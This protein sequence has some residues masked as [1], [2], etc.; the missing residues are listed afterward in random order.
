VRRKIERIRAG[1]AAA[2][3]A[4]L[5]GMRLV[6]RNFVTRRNRGVEI[7]LWSR[8][9]SAPLIQPQIRRCARRS[10]PGPQPSQPASPPAENP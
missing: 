3:A 10:A 6:L 8:V 5:R 1:D 7:A 4:S 2:H 9:G